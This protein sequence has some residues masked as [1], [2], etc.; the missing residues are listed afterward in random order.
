MGPLIDQRAVERYQQGI[1]AVKE[2]GGEILYGG[3]PLDLPG[4]FVEPALVNVCNHWEIV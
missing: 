1:T 4:H 2:Q 3:S